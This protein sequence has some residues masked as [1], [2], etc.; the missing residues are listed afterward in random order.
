MS[1]EFRTFVLFFN[2]GVH[3]KGFGLSVAEGRLQPALYFFYKGPLY[4]PRPFGGPEY[5]T[6]LYCLIENDMK[7]FLTAL[8]VGYVVVGVYKAVTKK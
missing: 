6:Y 4:Y 8:F 7:K 1:G 5:Y 2:G 3:W